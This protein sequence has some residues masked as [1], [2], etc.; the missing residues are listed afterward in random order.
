MCFFRAKHKKWSS[1]QKTPCKRCWLVVGQHSWDSWMQWQGHQ[2]AWFM[3]L[4][5]QVHPNV[6]FC[7]AKEETCFP[8]ATSKSFMPTKWRPWPN[9]ETKSSSNSSEHSTMAD[10]RCMPC[11][12]CGLRNVLPVMSAGWME[13]KGCIVGRLIDGC[14]STALGLSW[15]LKKIV[16]QNEKISQ[17]DFT[18]WRNISPSRGSSWQLG[19]SKEMGWMPEWQKILQVSSA[20]DLWF[21]ARPTFPATPTQWPW[22]LRVSEG[23]VA[24][25]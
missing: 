17:V 18:I 4:I 15:K 1:G 21:M 5:D 13:S 3:Q 11:P 19:V 25:C 8:E 14:W 22:S 12:F 2:H 24:S 23:K 6:W 10:L 9:H 20:S 16:K 7:L